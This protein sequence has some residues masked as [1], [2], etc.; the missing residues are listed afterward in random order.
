M[1]PASEHSSTQGSYFYYIDRQSGQ[2][3]F[4]N[5]RIGLLRLLE[6]HPFLEDVMLDTRKPCELFIPRSWGYVR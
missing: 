1:F 2:I 6:R 4:M 5:Y 3:D